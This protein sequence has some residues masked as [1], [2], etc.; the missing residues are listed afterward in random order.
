LAPVGL[1]RFDDFMVAKIESQMLIACHQMVEGKQAHKQATKQSSTADFVLFV[2]FF[3]FSNVF[4]TV[5]ST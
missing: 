3:D 4:A 1:K 2:S 5:E